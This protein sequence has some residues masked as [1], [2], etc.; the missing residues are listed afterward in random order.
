M[1]DKLLKSDQVQEVKCSRDGSGV[2]RGMLIISTALMLAVRVS[3][4]SFVCLK[5]SIV[6][7]SNKVTHDCDRYGPTTQGGFYFVDF[8]VVSGAPSQTIAL[9]WLR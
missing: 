2:V 5:K 8:E 3:R 4:T 1:W 7:V 6:N 9:F